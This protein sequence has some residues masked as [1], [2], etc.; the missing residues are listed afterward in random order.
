MPTSHPMS[1]NPAT[2]RPALL[3]DERGFILIEI[4]V[5]AI[6]LVTVSL[7]VF[8]T[9][10]RADQGAA[11]QVQRAQA[12]NLAQSEIER[13]RSLPVEDIAAEAASS[14]H[15]IVYGKVTFKIAT[16][17]KWVSDGQDEPECSTRTGGVDYMRI[18]QTITW[19]NMG[20]ARPV[21]LTSL[22]TPAAG[23][24]GDDTGSLSVHLTNRV[25]GPVPNVAISITGPSAASQTTNVNGCV[26]FPFIPVGQYT[27]KFQKPGYVNGDSVSAVADLAD[28]VAGETNKLQ[29]DYDSGGTTDAEFRTRRVGSG[30]PCDP[31]SPLNGCRT[32][33]LSVVFFN[34]AQSK[35]L[36][37]PVNPV[38]G[39]ATSWDGDSKPLFPFASNPSYSVY[40]GA[41]ALNNVATSDATN[42]NISPGSY[43]NTGV[44]WVP[45]LDVKV[46]SGTG[47]AAPGTPVNN[48]IVQVDTGC[49][50][51][52]IERRT[53]SDG[54][55]DDPGFPSAASVNVCASGVL[56]N[57]TSRR[58]SVGGFTNTKT[59]VATPANV[60]LQDP[61]NGNKTATG[62]GVS[63]F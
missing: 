38:G 14:P 54:K 24:G 63:C 23:S 26:V 10:T 51:P 56:P 34:T 46:W 58:V 15:S 19:S 11:T 39:L 42:V 6:I 35:P 37:L 61:V 22:Y 49:S 18:T 4:L 48:A 32:A 60:Y 59:D 25:G 9:L 44:V 57:G 47:P 40:A 62:P 53:R 50:P 21:A 16:V 52:F 31:T 13:I 12:S 36:V 30:D 55:L 27:V 45:A 29:Y 41:C 8:A 3:G 43:Q 33:P 20:N 17:A 7:A 5:S 28:V 1:A 2:D